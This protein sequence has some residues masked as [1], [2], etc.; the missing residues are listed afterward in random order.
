MAR[1]VFRWYFE[2]E[3]G[4]IQT[5]EGSRFDSRVLDYR[6]DVDLVLRKFHPAEVLA[7]TLITRDGLT[8]TQALEVAGIKTGRPDSAI[9]NIEIRIGQ[10]FERSSLDEF[11]KYVDYLR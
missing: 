10:A 1:Q 8:H 9:E 2:L 7:M 6:V 11:L 5:N 3:D 4:R